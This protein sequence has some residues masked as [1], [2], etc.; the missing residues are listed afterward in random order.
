MKCIIVDDE[1]PAIRLTKNYIEKLPFLELIGV[2]ENGIE[3]LELLNKHDIDLVFLDIQMPDLTGL[4]LIKALKNKPQIILITAYPDHAVEGFE[5]AVT[6]YL[7][8]PVSFD[9]FIKAVNRAR[10]QHQKSDTAPIIEQDHFFVKSNYKQIKV[11]FADILFIQGMGAYV[12]IRTT[13]KRYVV[14]QTMKKMKE[15]LPENMF[16]R[17]HKSYLIPLDKIETVYGSTIEIQEHKIPIGK[18]Y[19]EAFLAK[20]NS[21]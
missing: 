15:T 1:R 9:R 8:K 12:D 16:Y 18:S 5:L 7:V 6:D 13:D 20:I 21:I 4:D 2:C 3:A 11:L 10:D 19:R 14:H 17:V